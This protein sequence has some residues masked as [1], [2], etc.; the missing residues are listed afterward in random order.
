LLIL[1]RRWL[2]LA[3]EADGRKPAIP[4]PA[5]MTNDTREARHEDLP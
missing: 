5:G 3:S 1:G 2:Q 4:P